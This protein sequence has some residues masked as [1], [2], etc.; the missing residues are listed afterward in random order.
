VLVDLADERPQ[1]H[2]RSDLLPFCVEIG[3]I[4]DKMK[5]YSIVECTAS[6]NL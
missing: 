4:P 2:V 5:V 1:K 3:G 6:L